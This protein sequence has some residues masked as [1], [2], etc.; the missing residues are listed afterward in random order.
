MT[1][2][3][4]KSAQ[5]I[6][7]MCQKLIE[8]PVSSAEEQKI[9]GLL[10]IVERTGKLTIS[11]AGIIEKIRDYYLGPI[12][13]GIRK[14]LVMQIIYIKDPIE[15]KTRY[16]S[17][18]NKENTDT[19]NINMIEAAARNFADKMKRPIPLTAYIFGDDVY[20]EI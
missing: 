11:Q 1:E 4:S 2:Y 9:K 17:W 13:G 6:I 19:F 14:E 7:E 3:S 18:A 20:F 10:R 16:I 5:Q 15:F 12:D 8:F